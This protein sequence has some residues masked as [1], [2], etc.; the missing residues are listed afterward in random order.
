MENTM[1]TIQHLTRDQY[2]ARQEAQQVANDGI[3]LVWQLKNARPNDYKGGGIHAKAYE[4]LLDRLVHVLDAET[5]TLVINDVL[6]EVDP[7]WRV[8]TND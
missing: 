4:A 1:P 5:L 2:N 3:Q 8:K 6:N 7:S